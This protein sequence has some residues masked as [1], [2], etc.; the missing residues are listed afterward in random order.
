MLLLASSRKLTGLDFI[1]I[2]P[3][4][5]LSRL[6]G[7]YQRMLGL[8]KVLGGVLIF[9]RV[10][11]AY[12]STNQAHAQVDPSVANLDAIFAYMSVRFS[13]FD[14]VEM[15]AYFCHKSSC[16][17]LFPLRQALCSRVILASSP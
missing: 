9:G 1:H 5:G 16:F 4:P 2:T 17:S 13:Y 14:L 8:M 15:R 12:M 6:D 7:A 10:A 11:T 3:D